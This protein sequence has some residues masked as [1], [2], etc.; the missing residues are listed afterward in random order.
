MTHRFQKLAKITKDFTGVRRASKRFSDVVSRPIASLR[1]QEILNKI[2]YII[3]EKTIAK[4]YAH[5]TNFFSKFLAQI[6]YQYNCS[7]T[8]FPASLTQEALRPINM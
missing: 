2:H 8:S 5:M 7:F 3:N 1:L 6:L 4:Y